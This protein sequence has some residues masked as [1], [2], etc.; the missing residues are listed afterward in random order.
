[1]NDSFALLKEY[2]NRFGTFYGTEDFCIFLY[3]LAKMQRPKVILELGTGFGVT[4]FWLAR[5]VVE[6]GEGHIWTVDNGSHWQIAQEQADRYR[7]R[8][9][10]RSL[11]FAR[12]IES[13]AEKLGL[14]KAVTLLEQDMPP[15]PNIDKAVD[16]LFYDFKH[17][18]VEIMRLLVTFLPRLSPGASIFMDGV[19]TEFHSYVFI[20]HLVGM[21]NQGKLPRLM[22]ESLPDEQRHRLADIVRSSR[23]TL[24]HVTE[25]K[26]RKQNSCAWLKVDP[27]DVLPYPRTTMFF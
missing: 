25:R 14:S 22:T 18:A 23:F 2:A 8:D 7:L 1:M 9:E 19:S 16:L 17:S 21:L 6:N 11:G 24:V 26:D 12:F 4:T 13:H 10:E 27:I 5:A 20:E 15:Y 3:G